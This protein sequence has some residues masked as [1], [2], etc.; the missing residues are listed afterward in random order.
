MNEKHAAAMHFLERY[1][2]T[3]IVDRSDLASAYSHTATFS[4]QIL[5]PPYASATAKPPSASRPP[6]THHHGRVDVI[7]ALLDLPYDLSVRDDDPEAG[8]R[9]SLKQAIDW[10][11]C[12]A[13]EAGDLLL[14]CTSIV[15][16]PVGDEREEDWATGAG[17]KGKGKGKERAADE[18]P[19][20]EGSRFCAC[21]QRFVLRSRD[22]DEEDRST[23]G[24]WPFVAVAHH[25]LFRPLPR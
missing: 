22:W 3:F 18:P 17:G 19:N 25:M 11:F 6:A 7:A 8:E 9:G 1:L 21:E 20:G 2:S 13:R 24:V 23:P 16:M 15:P 12:W 10:D 5:R 14:L 4:F